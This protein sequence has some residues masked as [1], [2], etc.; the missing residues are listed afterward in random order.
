MHTLWHATY[1]IDVRI[2]LFGVLSANCLLV[3][4][5]LRN[6]FEQQGSLDFLARAEK[7]LGWR[8]SWIIQELEN[9]WA[10]LAALDSWD[11]SF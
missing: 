7:R 2:S 3:G 1:Y 11:A 10:E 4:Y 8:T 9:Q 6:S 5:C